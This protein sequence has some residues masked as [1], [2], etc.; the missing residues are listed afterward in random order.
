MDAMDEDIPSQG[1]RVRSTVTTVRKSKGRGF[2]DNRSTR[3]D[4]YGTYEGLEG[5][6]STGPLKCELS[7][8]ATQPL[9]H[10]GDSR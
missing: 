7:S 5:E 8:Y 1:Q 6:G 9:Q 3:E 2:Q 10:L 4:L